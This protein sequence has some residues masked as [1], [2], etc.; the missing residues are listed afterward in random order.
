MGES[1]QIGAIMDY[2]GS[3]G[4]E[5]LPAAVWSRRRVEGTS[6]RRPLILGL[7]S[8][9]SSVEQRRV[10]GASGNESAH[11]APEVPKDHRS[12]RNQRGGVAG[13]KFSRTPVEDVTL[14]PDV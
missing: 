13:V 7:H 1:P 8:P 14:V 12:P 4:I 3:N 2:T 5:Q 6:R 11:S 10:N 9:P